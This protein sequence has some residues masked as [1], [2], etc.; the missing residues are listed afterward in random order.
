MKPIMRL[1]EAL[2]TKVGKAVGA[3]VSAV[4]VG[5]AVVGAPVVGSSVGERVGE[6]VGGGTLH[7]VPVYPPVHV[8]TPSEQVPWPE[9]V[10]PSQRSTS[11][12]PCTTLSIPV[13]SPS[14]A[15]MAVEFCEFCWMSATAVEDV[16][17]RTMATLAVTLL[18]TAATVMLVVMLVDVRFAEDCEMAVVRASASFV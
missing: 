13:A 14:L 2:I 10:L 8:H 16:S 4:T 3:A 6:V 5:L 17:V 1:L 7:C 9:H 11:I 18:A 15:T 12:E